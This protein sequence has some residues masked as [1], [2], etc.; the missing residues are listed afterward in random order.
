MKY[1]RIFESWI[2]NEDLLINESVQA[3]KAFMLKRLADRLNKPVQ[4]L[5]PEEQAQA[6]SEPKY[7]E[8]LALLGDKYRGYAGAFTNFIFLQRISIEQL[9]LLLTKI[10][11]N[12][13]FIGS[14]PHTVAEYSKGNPD[15]EAR[16]SGFEALMDQFDQ[17]EFRR[18][19]KWIIDKL[20]RAIRDKARVATPEEQQALFRIGFN[21]ANEDTVIKDR[22]MKKSNRFLDKPISDFIQ[23]ASNF[24]DAQNIEGGA[25]KL[26]AQA[27]ELAPA[28]NVM[29]D[30][31]RYVVMS[32]R[33]EAAQKALC[34]AANWCINNW[35]W[36]QYATGAVQINIFDFGVPTTDPLHITGT[37]IYYSGKVRTSHDINDKTITQSDN[38]AEHFT[39]LGYPTELVDSIV[40]PL[41]AECGVKQVL[42]EGASATTGKA[43]VDKVMTA[44]HSLQLSDQRMAQYA[45]HEI[46]NV[47]DQEMGQLI[48]MQDVIDSF[49][50]YGV[51]ST[52]AAKL[53]NKLI[54]GSAIAETDKQ[55]ILDKT[56]R[57]FSMIE[58]TITS[59]VSKFRPAILSKMQSIFTVKDQILAMIAD[60]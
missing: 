11:D 8:L 40:K 42:D 59:D 41:L 51:L 55:A 34:S 13:E 10:A 3:A 45:E 48:K 33:T 50:Q 15:K 9:R 29:Y 58:K 24:A 26:A 57:G 31:D 5:S 37:T 49:K 27:E 17:I 12:R 46:V 53:Y 44:G 18:K 60:R 35:A 54:A 43:F 19:G 36:K 22:L 7:K 47:I 23:Y 39:K 14:L 4:E 6:L 38:P 2:S 1:L 16:I 56:L 52:F 20:P 25:I 30:D 21:L 28:V 32:I